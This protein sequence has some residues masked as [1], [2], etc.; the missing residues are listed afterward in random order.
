GVGSDAHQAV[1]YTTMLGWVRAGKVKE[2]VLRP[3]SI[4]GTLS[5]PQKLDG[6]TVTDF[7]SPLPKDDR[8][9][10]LLDD[11]GVKIKVE[12]EDAPLLGAGAG[13]PRPSATRRRSCS[14]TSSTAAGGRAAPGSA[15]AT[16]SASRHSTSS[17]PRWMASSAATSWW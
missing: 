8:L 7:R 14:S 3:D 16:T 1:D 9:V 4:T 11:K 17:C 12:N 15:A 6:H 10:P 5:E 13:S 2:V